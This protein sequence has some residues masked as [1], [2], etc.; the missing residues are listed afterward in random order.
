MRS[1]AQRCRCRRTGPCR[2]AWVDI[3]CLQVIPRAEDTFQAGKGRV[4]GREGGIYLPPA[5]N[6][7]PTDGKDRF[8]AS[9]ADTRSSKLSWSFMR[10]SCKPPCVSRRVFG[11][12][13]RAGVPSTR[14][15]RRCFSPG[16]H[17][18]EKGGYD[19][20]RAEYHATEDRQRR[21]RRAGAVSGTPSGVP[22]AVSHLSG[23]PARTHPPAHTCL[24]RRS[25]GSFRPCRA[26]RQTGRSTS[27]TCRVCLRPHRVGRTRACR[28]R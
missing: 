11:L 13:A 27:M 19:G 16:G 21:S 25:H 26:W 6:H 20:L 7:E 28:S 14:S 15:T 2:R 4:T 10:F 22:G 12:Q 8:E 23:R 24:A 9:A 5:T 18:R 3:P 17:G 1:R